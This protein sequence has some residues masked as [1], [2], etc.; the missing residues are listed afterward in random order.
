[1]EPWI[2]K[3]QI[4]TV[5][6]L[7]NFLVLV[8]NEQLP[9][10]RQKESAGNMKPKAVKAISIILAAVLLIFATVFFCIMS[11][12]TSGAEFSCNHRNRDDIKV[13]DRTAGFGI[14]AGLV[15]AVVALVSVPI[16]YL[17]DT[18]RSNSVCKLTLMP[19]ALLVWLL[20]LIAWALLAK[21]ITDFHHTYAERLPNCNLPDSWAMGLVF[22]LLSWICSAAV[23]LACIASWSVGR[24][25][26]ELFVSS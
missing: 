26:P 3:G 10:K 12:I 15:G 24:H 8:P 23:T 2:L 20:F 21:D 9:R 6:P 11:Y 13:S 22:G 4:N 18:G 5:L 19:F 14:T 16:F 1:M 17:F 25:Y 7:A